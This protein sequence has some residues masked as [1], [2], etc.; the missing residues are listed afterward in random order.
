MSNF[1]AITVTLFLVIDAFGNIPA[2][3]SLVQKLPTRRQNWI[4]AREL[5]I[6]LGIMVL[7]Q[8]VGPILLSLFE[9]TKSTVQIAGGIVIFL[10]ALRLIFSGD[11]E[12]ENFW[13]EGEPFIVPL[14]TPLIAG[15]SLLALIMIYAQEEPHNFTV[16]GAIFVAWFFSA[17]VLIFARPI[18]RLMGEKG[19][20]ACQSLMGLLVGLVAVQMFLRGIVGLLNEPL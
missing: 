20:L 14:A 9:I 2:Y 4:A 5:L 11:K 3:L 7:F 10:I 16:I 19:L 18:F 8:F 13:G 15:P 1:I 12:N 17:A 6:A